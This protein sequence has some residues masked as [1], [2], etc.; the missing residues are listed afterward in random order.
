MY[1]PTATLNF[2]GPKNLGSRKVVVNFTRICLACLAQCATTYNSFLPKINANGRD[3]LC[4]EFVI[5]V[6]MQKRCLADTR[7]AERQ[8]LDQII[9]ICRASLAR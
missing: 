1:S 4:L 9:I 5:C 7:I 2:G 8:E 3:E 6:L